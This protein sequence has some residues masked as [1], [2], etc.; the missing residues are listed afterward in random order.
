MAV[1]GTSSNNSNK[2]ILAGLAELRKEVN[3]LTVA[4]IGNVEEGRPGLFERVRNLEEWVS[5]EKK[6]IYMIVGIIITDVVTHLWA[7]IVK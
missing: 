1:K 2:Q 7:L 6:L 3:T 4:F 5:N